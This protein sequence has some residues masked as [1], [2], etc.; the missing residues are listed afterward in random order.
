MSS[1]EGLFPIKAKS[2]EREGSLTLEPT[3]RLSKHYSP[4]T[5]VM[6]KPFRFLALHSSAQRLI[7]GSVKF[8][9]IS[10][11]MGLRRS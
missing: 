6:T 11:L 7:V 2:S 4:L 1:A 5:Y 8:G 3:W 10:L 9:R